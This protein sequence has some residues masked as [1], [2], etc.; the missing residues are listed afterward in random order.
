MNSRDTLRQA[1]NLFYYDQA[2]TEFP[3]IYWYKFFSP[4]S[5]DSNFGT[6]I[7]SRRLFHAA[8]F[9]NSSAMNSNDINNLGSGGPWQLREIDPSDESTLVGSKRN[10]VSYFASGWDSKVNNASI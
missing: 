9:L 2:L 7:W 8:Y 5:Q 1:S 6:N 10:Y 4:L 3:A